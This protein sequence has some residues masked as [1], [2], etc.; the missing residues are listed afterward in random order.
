[1]ILELV[2]LAKRMWI[3]LKMDMLMFIKQGSGLQ[4]EC[5]GLGIKY[6]IAK[7]QTDIPCYNGWNHGIRHAKSYKK[8]GCSE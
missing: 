2:H 3:I 5:T 7:I 8:I 6:S 4:Q 1:M